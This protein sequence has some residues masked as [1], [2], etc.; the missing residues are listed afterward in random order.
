MD[1]AGHPFCL[2]DWSQELPA[3]RKDPE[4]AGQTIDVNSRDPVQ[5]LGQGCVIGSGEPLGAV[6]AV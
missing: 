6:N 1:P 3:N 2:C 5:P 4:E